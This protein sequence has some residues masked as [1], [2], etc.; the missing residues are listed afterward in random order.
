M[1]NGT[2]RYCVVR[3]NPDATVDSSFQV[4]TGRST[5]ALLLQPDGKVVIGGDFG[6]VNGV[7]RNR[8]A[9]VNANGTLDLTF[10]PGIGPNRVVRAL[11]QDSAGNIYAGGDFSTVSG[12]AHR[13]I[14]KLTP[15]GAIDPAFNPAGGGA[16]SCVNAITPADSAGH[17][18][19]G[20]SFSN[21]NGTTAR[22]IARIDA[23]TG[24]IDPT[25][26]TGSGFGGTVNALQVAPDGKYYAG[27]SFGTFNNIARR[28]VARLNNNGTLDV[29]FAGP[30]L[31]FS[32][33]INSLA[34]QNGKVYA[35]GGDLEGVPQGVLIKLT[36]SGASDGSFN[37]GAGIDVF[38]QFGYGQFIARVSALAIQADG[39]LLVG[40]IFNRYNAV[41]RTCLAR[42][43]GPLTPPPPSPTPTPPTPTPTPSATP[44]STPTP[45]AN[46][47]PTPTPSPI[48]GAQPTNLS[49]R[50]RVQTGDNVGIGGFIITGTAPKQVLLRALG[51]SI[52]G[53]TG[54]LADPVI[55]L[56][57]PA[58][59]TT[60]INNNWQ[61]DPAQTVLIQATGLAPTN[62][63]ESAIHATLNPGA[64]TGVV[65][66][67]GNTSGIGLVEVYD[68]RPA[69][70]SKLG[71]IST[72]AL[73]GTGN[74]IV[75]AGFIL[76]N[77]SGGTRI[78]ARGIGGSLT[79]FGVPNALANPTLELRNSSGALLAA[80]D[81]WEDDL[82]QAAELTAAGLAPTNASESGIAII[83]G[84]GQYT[85]LLAGQGNTTGIGLVEVYDRGP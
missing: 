81:N 84:P 46:P 83:L 78:V 36:S 3:I 61:D 67:S 82:A 50:M 1:V 45:S 30:A 44:S 19:I 76:G 85:A 73:V 35:G 20:G 23:T 32:V 43:T 72:R 6:Q 47:T 59:F 25:F 39:R 74:D 14:V 69:V 10:D 55:E 70:P 64:Y 53:L 4:D 22:S 7:P 33:S 16:S 11:A 66:G 15:T 75:I 42:L 21:Y 12:V 49:T 13:G 51:P 9:R 28:A 29:G 18:V 52:T 38:P 31:P 65:R 60:V 17:I 68:L 2:S 37:T 56:H 54:V 40:G 79:L 26:Q 24:A 5:R 57:G 27:G 58:G 77:S 48:P 80:N 71:N 63:L 8:I 41:P 34:L 62:N